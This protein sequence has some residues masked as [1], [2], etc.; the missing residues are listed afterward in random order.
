MVLYNLART[1]IGFLHSVE[2]LRDQGSHYTD[3]KTEPRV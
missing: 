3:D 2:D 1:Q